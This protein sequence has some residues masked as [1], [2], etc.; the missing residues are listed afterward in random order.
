MVKVLGLTVMH[1]CLG[2]E[3]NLLRFTAVKQLFSAAHLPGYE[4][5][6]GAAS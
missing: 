4:L 2:G 6:Q 5:F 3:D 1:A